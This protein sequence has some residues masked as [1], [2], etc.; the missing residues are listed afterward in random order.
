[1]AEERTYN[2]TDCSLQTKISVARYDGVVH[3]KKASQAFESLEPLIL[4]KLLF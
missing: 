1:M 4:Y 3:T 2:A